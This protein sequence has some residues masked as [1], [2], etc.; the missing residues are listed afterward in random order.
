MNSQSILIIILSLI[1]IFILFNYRNIIAMLNSHFGTN[2][3]S[4][5][6]DT[7]DQLVK[8]YISHLYDAQ[9]ESDY[10][11]SP[12]KK[13]QNPTPLPSIDIS[14]LTKEKF[15][16]LT[17]NFTTPLVV[18]G[19]LKDSPAVKKWNLDF[20]ARQYGQ[21]QLPV[22]LNADIKA[23]QSYLSSKESEKYNYITLKDFVNSI[24]KGNKLYINNVSRIFGYHPE[25]LNDLNLEKIE[26]YT[27]ENLKD[28]VHITNLFM[29]GKSTG[30][31]L[32]CSITGNFFYNI[33]GRKL[34]YLIDPKYTRY[35]KPL[36]SRTGLFAVSR[37]DICNAKPGDYPLNIPRFEVILEEGDLLFNPPFYWHAITN[38]TDYTIACANRFTNFWSGFRNNPLF[39][40]IFFSHPI[41]NYRDFGQFKTRK[42]AN[43][44]FDQA[45]LSDILKEKKK[46]Q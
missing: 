42:D 16:K 24:K 18:R 3:S 46:I 19:F 32:H 34:W 35:L 15:I 20:F 33:K 26:K 39:A 27:G 14:Q 7:H 37:L 40:F 28:E 13:Y 17:N 10:R 41:A 25:L 12:F 29:G 43:I 21:T 1:I 23:H 22:I 44:G 31:S 30:T 4:Q 6:S 11:H 8:N 5:E 36:L 9:V 45:L 2:L 38:Q